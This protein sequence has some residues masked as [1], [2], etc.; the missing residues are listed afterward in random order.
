MR[1]NFDL[2]DFVAAI[3]TWLIVCVVIT[4]AILFGIFVQKAGG[5]YW[6]LGY[7]VFWWA[8]VAV[9]VYFDE[10]GTL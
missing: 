4:G 5:F 1:K 7:L 9:A 6:T 10:K 8:V 2:A 3:V